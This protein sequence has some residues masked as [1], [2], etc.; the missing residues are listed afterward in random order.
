[1]KGGEQKMVFWFL[2]MNF[3]KKLNK[4]SKV[5]YNDQKLFRFYKPNIISHLFNR[6]EIVAGKHTLSL[7]VS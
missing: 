5:P 4:L 3:H 1:M 6:L 2:L 7:Y